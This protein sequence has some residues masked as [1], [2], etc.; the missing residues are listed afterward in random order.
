MG[1]V[2]KHLRIP[3]TQKVTITCEGTKYDLFAETLSEGGMYIRKKVPFPVSTSLEVSIPL[4]DSSPL[5]FKGRVIYTKGLN[6]DLFRVPPGM[7]IEFMNVSAEFAATL[8]SF[9]KACLA[10]DIWEKQKET[11]IRKAE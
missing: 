6:A 3:F 1:F 9:I 7:A 11:F 5:S 4:T 8:K 10:K 2:R